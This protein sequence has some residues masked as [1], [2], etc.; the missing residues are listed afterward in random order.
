MPLSGAEPAL[1]DVT[2]IA[3]LKSA[4][5]KS[6]ECNATVT[7]AK[8]T[9]FASLFYLEVDNI[10]KTEDGMYRSSVTIYCRLPLGFDDRKRFYHT[11]LR[12][13]A[14]FVANSRAI[15]CVST[16]PSGFPMFRCTFDLLLKS[17]T[18]DL[19]VRLTGV[20]SEP[21]LISG[22]PTQLEWLVKAQN[23]EMP[24]GSIDNRHVEKQLPSTPQKRRA[25]DISYL[26]IYLFIESY[27]V[28]AAY[29]AAMPG[30]TG[31]ADS[32]RGADVD[33]RRP[34]SSLERDHL[35]PTKPAVFLN[36]HL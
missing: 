19:H 27:S 4:A 34:T 18:D 24:F 30:V 3:Q 26:F 13:H 2:A 17:M 25:S 36:H 12:K 22:M 14:L 6:I 15:P 31:V 1:D 33:P 20:T 28:S 21:T 5:S 16:L 32:G 29:C 35:S 23:L 10:H 9:M 11:L 7:K 8:D